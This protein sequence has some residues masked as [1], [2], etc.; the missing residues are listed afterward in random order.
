MCLLHGKKHV[1]FKVTGLA[2]QDPHRETVLGPQAYFR[3]MLGDA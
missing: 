1:S 2:K 3:A